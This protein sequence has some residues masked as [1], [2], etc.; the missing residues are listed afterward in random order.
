MS[1]KTRTANA[2]SIRRAK[3]AKIKLIVLVGFLSTTIIDTVVSVLLSNSSLYQSASC[4]I[5]ENL[6]AQLL[7][8][9]TSPFSCSAASSGLPCLLAAVLVVATPCAPPPQTAAEQRTT[10]LFLCVSAPLNHPIA[11]LQ[12]SNNISFARSRAVADGRRWNSDKTICESGSN[13]CTYSS[14]AVTYN[15]GQKCWDTCTFSLKIAPLRFP[16]PPSPS[17]SCISGLK[18]HFFG[19]T[20]TRGEG[21]RHFAQTR[22]S[23]A[24]KTERLAV[25]RT[26]V[27]DCRTKS[28]K[29]SLEIVRCQLQC[30]ESTEPFF[31]S[32][33]LLHTLQEVP[34]SCW[35]VRRRSWTV[36]KEIEEAWNRGNDLEGNKRLTLKSTNE[37]AVTTN[38][39][40][41]HQNRCD[42]T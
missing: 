8:I 6:E 26:F 1:E 41:K 27:Q 37:A 31:L 30:R 15:P 28:G 33:F 19:A 36:A 13:C 20:L 35:K 18:V 12:L 34:E 29:S 32:R 40:R 16:P 21:G 4:Q 17:Q 14:P 10:F 2:K 23:R 7:F 3:I 38:Q 42:L 5:E 24:S 25:P 11:F 9:M 22:P 39:R